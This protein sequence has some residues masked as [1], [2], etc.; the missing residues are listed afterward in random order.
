MRHLDS[1]FLS[2]LDH[3]QRAR[4]YQ[5]WRKYLVL[6]HATQ[7]FGVA[8]LL[9]W[10]FRL[11]PNPFY[12]VARAVWTPLFFACFFFG[13]WGSLLECPRCGQQFRGWFSRGQ[14]LYF[15]DECQSCGLRK[16]QLS[17]VAKPGD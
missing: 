13:L 10:L 6:K 11:A 7:G 14:R 16:E 9:C 15:G 17:A 1:G 3:E 12:Q 5:W 8:V 4:Y 2:N